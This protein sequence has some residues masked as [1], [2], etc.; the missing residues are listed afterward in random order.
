MKNIY[1]KPNFKFVTLS[2][3]S[4]E[5][6]CT[7]SIDYSWQI[8]GVVVDDIFTVFAKEPCD[9]SPDFITVCQHTGPANSCV[10]GS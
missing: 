7:L 9:T 5:S 3:G 2:T 8:C 10:F 1:Q 4:N 6:A